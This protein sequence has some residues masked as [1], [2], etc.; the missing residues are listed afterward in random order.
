MKIEDDFVT[1]YSRQT[2]SNIGDCGIR[3]VQ[4][5]VNSIEQ[6]DSSTCGA[7]NIMSEATQEVAIP[8]EWP[9]T[10]TCLVLNLDI[11]VCTAER[12]SVADLP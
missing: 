2:I 7:M 6:R 10:V 4:R 3:D 5:K 9:V 1:T 12:M 8:K 11:V